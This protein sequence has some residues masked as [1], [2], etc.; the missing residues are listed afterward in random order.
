MQILTPE[1]QVGL[2]MGSAAQARHVAVRE[3]I[4]AG[5]FLWIIYRE[6]NNN[7]Y[8]GA[9]KLLRIITPARRVPYRNDVLL[10]SIINN[11]KR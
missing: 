10:V 8:Y 5:G 3:S 9:D 6:A 1:K 4:A 7:L 11:V 2:K